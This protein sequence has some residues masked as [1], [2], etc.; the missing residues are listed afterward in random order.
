MLNLFGGPFYV[1]SKQDF[2]MTP[3]NSP[4]SQPIRT[5]QAMLGDKVM[6]VAIALSAL[7]SVVLGANFVES[8][9]AWGA[10]AVLV[11]L[12]A[13]TYVVARGTLASSLVL[14]VVQMAFVALHI[15]LS[16]GLTEFH[17]GV[18]VS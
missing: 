14:A 9:L 12:A 11:V 18:F 6:L 16:H 8:G 17:F 13:L 7:T 4:A 15:H 2:N 10:S 5:S 3:K 1:F